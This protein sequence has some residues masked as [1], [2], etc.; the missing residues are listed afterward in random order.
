MPTDYANQAAALRTEGDKQQKRYQQMG[1]AAANRGAYQVDYSQAN[2][3][4]QGYAE[5]RAHAGDTRM[6][7]QTALNLQQQAATGEAPSRAEI[8]GSQMAGQALNAQMAAAAGARGGPLAQAAAQQQASA[9]TAQYLSQAQNQM[10]GLRAQ[11]MAQARDSFMAGASGMRGQDYQG[12]QQALAASAQSAQQAQFQGQMEMGQRQLNQQ[13]QMGYEEAAQGAYQYGSD[14][15]AKYKQADQE[16]RDKNLDRFANLAGGVLGAVGGVVSD[17]RAKVGIQPMSGAAAGGAAGGL[18][19]GSQLGPMA[20][21]AGLGALGAKLLSDERGKVGLSPLAQAPMGELEPWLPPNTFPS[22]ALVSDERSKSR[23]SPMSFGEKLAGPQNARGEYVGADD[24]SDRATMPT[25]GHY[26]DYGVSPHVTDAGRGVL[27]QDPISA[28]ARTMDGGSAGGAETRHAAARG[29]ASGGS[30][31]K[32][33]PE[34]LEAYVRQLEALA[35]TGSSV[36]AAS[37]RYRPEEAEPARMMDA[38]GSGKTWRYREG[39]PGTD[40]GAEQHYGTTTQDLRQTPMGASMVKPGPGG[41][42]AIDTREAVGPMLAG[43]GNLN[44]RL[45]RIEGKGGR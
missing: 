31:R 43:L 36:D 37:S 45:R 14:M 5:D 25:L 19:G 20:V 11:E 12:A 24:G 21:G 22:M 44:E 18:G 27:V 23:T 35:K 41:Y 28:R 32:A 29:G 6:R 9:G 39:V 16:A 42:E 1:A 26:A 7:Q 40:Q 8:L 3:D 4:R 17:P 15:E 34:D 10:A 2:A 38:I 30:S 33:A 13:A